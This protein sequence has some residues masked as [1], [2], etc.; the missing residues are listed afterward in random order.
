ME[1]FAAMPRKPKGFCFPADLADRIRYDE[2]KKR[3]VYRGF[4]S[5]AEFDRLCL[6]SDDWCYR[7]P[8]EDLFRR[9]TPEAAR[10]R[11]LSRLASVFF[12]F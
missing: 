8:L 11:L 1:Q 5:K 2:D 3:L 6:V 4:M 12:S 10:P 9:C 7:R